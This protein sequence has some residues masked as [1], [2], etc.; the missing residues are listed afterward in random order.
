MKAAL[1]TTRQFGLRLGQ[2]GHR[3]AA[4]FGG[5]IPILAVHR[6]ANSLFAGKTSVT[7]SL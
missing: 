6:T 4:Q 5:P 2:S 1:E 7:F 3:T